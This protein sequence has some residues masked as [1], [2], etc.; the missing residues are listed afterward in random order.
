M[1]TEEQKLMQE[2]LKIILG[3]V[4]HEVKVL[5]IRESRKWRQK[6]IILWG[7]IPN[8]IKITSDKPE[9]VD[10]LTFLLVSMPDAVIDLFF[11]YAADLNREVIESAAT[12]AEMAKGFEQIVE[13][14]FPLARSLLGSMG[15]LSL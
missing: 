11:Q 7:Q 14:S 6:L 10:A 4:S 12:D 8:L 3:G 13:V 5:T 2:P 1:R 9:F 15:R